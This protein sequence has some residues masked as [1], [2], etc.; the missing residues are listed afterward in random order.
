MLILLVPTIIFAQNDTINTEKLIFTGD[1][2]FRIEP[3]WNS[4]KS[5]GTY[6]KDRTRLRYR[7]HFGFNYQY[8]QWISFG[9]RIRTGFPI[10]QQDPQLTLGDGFKEFNTLPVGFEKI[11]IDLIGC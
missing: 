1:F 6:R 3:D 2:R 10:K 4:R 7:A 11:F 9:A 5:D 8:N